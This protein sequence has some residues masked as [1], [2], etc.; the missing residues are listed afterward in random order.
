MELVG[1]HDVDGGQ[2]VT[3]IGIGV[4]EDVGE[5]L[6]ELIGLSLGEALLWTASI[7]CLRTGRRWDCGSG[8]CASEG[9][10]GCGESELHFEC[11][12]ETSE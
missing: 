4:F 5:A 3:E 8:D 7:N 9:Q 12:V 10:G 6:D 11:V 2:V 1:E